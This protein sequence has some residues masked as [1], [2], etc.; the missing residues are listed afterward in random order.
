MQEEPLYEKKAEIM[1]FRAAKR[2]LLEANRCS[3]GLFFAVLD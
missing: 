3:K 2:M 1:A